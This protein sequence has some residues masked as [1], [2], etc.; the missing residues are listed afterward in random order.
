MLY[1]LKSGNDYALID[2]QK[3]IWYTNKCNQ[4]S[5]EPTINNLTTRYFVPDIGVPEMSNYKNIKSWIKVSNK[6]S[7]CI[8]I[9]SYFSI[10]SIEI[11]NMLEQHPEFFI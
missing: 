11:T 8:D 5:W 7:D 2:F 1:I 4:H 9:D 6:N 10:S 3:N